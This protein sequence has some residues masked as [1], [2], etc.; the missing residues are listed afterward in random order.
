M[1]V[2]D[3]LRSCLF[4]VNRPSYVMKF[5]CFLSSS[6]VAQCINAII[7]MSSQQLARIFLCVV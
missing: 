2:Y 1:I 3:E 6:H 5:K 7:L 4:I